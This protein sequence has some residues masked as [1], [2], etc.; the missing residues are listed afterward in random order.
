MPGLLVSVRSADEARAAVEG[1]AAVVDVKEPDRGPLGRADAATWRA[2][3]AVV[4]LSIPVSVA[5]GE[6]RDHDGD[7]G[8]LAG[9]AY[10]KLGLAGAGAGWV[11]A[12]AEARRQGNAKVRRATID[13]ARDHPPGP[14]WVA[15]AYADWTLADSPGPDAVLAA[16]LDA[17]DCAGVLVDTWDKSRPSP[18]EASPA[19]LDRVALVR[20]SGRFVALAGGLDLAAIARLA[21]LAPD[22]FAVRGAACAGS[23][24]RARVDPAR[25]A[26]LARAAA[27]CPIDRPH[28]A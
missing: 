8:D 3:R 16:A 18:L 15:V 19:W 27:S 14:R 28:Q 4:P 7:A 26:E 20:R 21:P 2:V 9:I 10:C 22:L 24:R 5:L 12:W 11:G 17:P 1:G 23:D 13:R 25:V 6:L